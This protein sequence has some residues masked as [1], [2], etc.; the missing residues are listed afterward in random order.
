MLHSG[1]H[2]TITGVLLAFAIPF[3]KGGEEITFLYS[4]A[5]AA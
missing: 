2:P 1:V 5:F 4:A 3:A